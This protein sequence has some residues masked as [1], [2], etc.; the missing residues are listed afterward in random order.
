MTLKCCLISLGHS[1]HLAIV[2]QGKP[3]VQFEEGCSFTS[4]NRESWGRCSSLGGTEEDE[5]LT[6]GEGDQ[7]DFL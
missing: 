7:V 6:A 4:S 2:W 5:S 3:V 1:I